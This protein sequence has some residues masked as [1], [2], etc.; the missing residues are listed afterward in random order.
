MNKI[1]EHVIKR[2]TNRVVTYDKGKL[3]K[4]KFP[5][6]GSTEV[7][8]FT[9]YGRKTLNMYLGNVDMGIAT[10][11]DIIETL[12]VIERAFIDV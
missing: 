8:I 10:E 9:L 3:Y 11:D 5:L 6:F 1:L 12:E 4:I 2:Y 7:I